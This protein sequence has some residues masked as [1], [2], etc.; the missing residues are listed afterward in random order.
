VNTSRCRNKL[1]SRAQIFRARRN[2]RKL[3]NDAQNEL[4]QRCE[5]ASFFHPMQ[6]QSTP[7]TQPPCQDNLRD[8]QSTALLSFNLLF[9]LQRVRSVTP[10]DTQRQL[11]LEQSRI[12][13]PLTSCSRN[14]TMYNSYTH[15]FQYVS[16][17]KSVKRF[18]Q[19]LRFTAQ[20]SGVE[21]AQ[22]LPESAGLM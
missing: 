15:M 14:C 19:C 9:A 2:A 1:K 8:Q 7:L 22:T 4:Y 13:S 21:W 11:S 10:R 20:T 17:R 18:Y 16:G 5:P 12:H 3:S 6:R